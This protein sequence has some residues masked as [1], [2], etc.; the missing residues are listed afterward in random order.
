MAGQQEGD[1]RH[2]ERQAQQVQRIA[3]QRMPV[4]EEQ[5]AQPPP[6]ALGARVLGTPFAPPVDNAAPRTGCSPFELVL[7]WPWR[8]LADDGTLSARRRIANLS[9][10]RRRESARSCAAQSPSASAR[11]SRS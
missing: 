1:R 7:S 3:Q 5:P 4:A 2:R 10:P 9:R 6:E 11:S 8:A